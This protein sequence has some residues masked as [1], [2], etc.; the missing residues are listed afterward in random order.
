MMMR[1]WSTGMK[2][3]AASCVMAVTAACS[4]DAPQELLAPQFDGT[5]GS[6]WKVDVCKISDGQS[7]DFTV[8]A[9]SGTVLAS[10]FTIV[11]QPR[12]AAPSCKPVWSGPAGAPVTVTITEVPSPNYILDEVRPFP[13]TGLT[14]NGNVVTLNQDFLAT[15]NGGQAFITFKNITVEQPSLRVSKTAGNA[16]VNVGAPLSFTMTVTNDGPG[17]ATGVTLTDALPGGT[18]INWSIASQPAGNPCTI[19]GAAP[20]QTLNCN[21]GDLAAGQSA[22][23]TVTSATTANTTC[24]EYVNTVTVGATNHGNVQATADITVTGCTRDGLEGCTPGYWKQKQHFDNWGSYVPTGAGASLYNTVFGVNLFSA[25]TTL[26][27]ALS[28]GGGGIYRFGRHSVAALLSAQSSGV[29]YGMTAA[30]VIAAVQHAVATGNF[31][32]A[33]DEFE[34]RNERQCPLN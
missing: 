30:G 17:A 23:V 34:R 31:D 7:A 3:V 20:A 16:V 26:L 32:A 13:T 5:T 21:F 4:G 29:D 6:V 10:S 27:Q 1:R 12:D 24:A 9:T 15:A 2:L 33:A 25:N 14:V 28:T 11:G 22:A 19:A 18:G 8:S